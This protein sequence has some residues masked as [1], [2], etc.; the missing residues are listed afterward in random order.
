MDGEGLQFRSKNLAER[1]ITDPHKPRR[2]IL[3]TSEPD[4]AEPQ[5][6]VL[7]E[8]IEQIKSAPQQDIMPAGWLESRRTLSFENT[9]PI[10]RTALTRLRESISF[11]VL[12][13]GLAVF[14]LVGG[15]VVF[16]LGLRAGNIPEQK[17]VTVVN[18]SKKS[19][20]I[21]PVSAVLGA[22]SNTT[23]ATSD[24]TAANTKGS[25][26]VSEDQ[27][28]P[29]SIDSYAV[30]PTH[31][32]YM[33]IPSLNITKARVMRS[34]V[35]L[36]GSIELPKTIWDGGWY[37]S[38]ALP[39]DRQGAV[40]IIGHVQGETSP[41]LF[42]DLYKLQTGAEIVLTLGDGTVVRYKVVAKQDVLDDNIDKS[43]VLSSRDTS[44]ASLTLMT[45]VGERNPTTG[46]YEKRQ[47]VFAIRAN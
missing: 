41:G 13:A 9:E 19:L 24:A 42:Y 22:S 17:A 18:E 43:G 4:S 35:E 46:Q 7:V 37:E 44:A 15:F 34:S 32:R 5:P 31:I 10:K 36:N 3:V 20:D 12:F 29:E 33:A 39:T 27:P 38:S 23:N 11:K 26:P 40:L 2:P 47:A 14:V 45:A 30:S 8:Q 6:P 25:G 28:S 1:Y 16:M 21:E